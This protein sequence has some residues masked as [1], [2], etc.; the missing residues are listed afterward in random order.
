[1]INA[2]ETRNTTYINDKFRYQFVMY[3]MSNPDRLYCEQ[4]F[5]KFSILS[6]ISSSSVLASNFFYMDNLAK[7]YPYT[8]DNPFNDTIKN[9]IWSNDYYKYSSNLKSNATKVYKHLFYYYI[10]L[11]LS[12]NINSKVKAFQYPFAIALNEQ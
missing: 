9:L 2:N 6:G 7:T 3:E 5:W 8:T 11:T 1:M 12:D 4:N 10:S